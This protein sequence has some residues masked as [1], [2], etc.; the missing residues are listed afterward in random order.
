M[1]VQCFYHCSLWLGHKSSISCW[2]LE[3]SIF[4]LGFI[5][6]SA[7]VDPEWKPQCSSS[8][9]GLWT[10]RKLKIAPLATSV[11]LGFSSCPFSPEGCYTPMSKS[12]ITQQGLSRE[13]H[14][15]VPHPRRHPM[16]G[17]KQVGSEC[18]WEGCV[19]RE[20]RSFPRLTAQ[21]DSGSWWDI[22]SLSTPDRLSGVT[23]CRLHQK[24][25]QRLCLPVCHTQSYLQ[26]ARQRF[27]EFRSGVIW[28][29]GEAT[30]VHCAL[31]TTPQPWV[32]VSVLVRRVA[33]NAKTHC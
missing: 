30:Q 15:P 5:K 16:V 3:S 4:W 10:D 18:K 33:K 31:H 17:R 32:Q 21:N 27:G 22:S 13:I 26:L 24:D 6:S 7:P 9:L 29:S 8:K 19:N 11:V 28:G 20:F 23:W 12:S 25:F 2:R 14:I 1:W